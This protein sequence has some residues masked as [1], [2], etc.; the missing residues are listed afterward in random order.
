MV[1]ILALATIGVGYG[2]W[3]KTLVIEGKVRTGEL[4]AIYSIERVAE[5]WD[6]NNPI[7]EEWEGKDVA[8]CEA[9]LDASG[10]KPDLPNTGPQA[11]KV[12]ITNSYPSFNCFVLYDI[13]NTGSIPIKVHLPEYSKDGITWVSGGFGGFDDPMHVNSWPPS[14]TYED[15]AQLEPGESVLKWL[16]FHTGQRATMNTDYTFYVRHFVHQWNEEG[17]P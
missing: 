4:N 9:V 1:L 8:L 3:A 17:S 7:G 5:S 6:F 12:T 10:L 2:L 13:T 11:I 16:H 15:D 14:P